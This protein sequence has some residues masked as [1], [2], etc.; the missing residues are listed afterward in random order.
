[1]R[2]SDV[3]RVIDNL[4]E[5]LKVGGNIMAG[6][7][8]YREVP[9]S[10]YNPERYRHLDDDTKWFALRGHWVIRKKPNTKDDWYVA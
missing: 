6:D 10:E 8:G 1:M 9:L 4:T 3:Q 2:D 7:G 5:S